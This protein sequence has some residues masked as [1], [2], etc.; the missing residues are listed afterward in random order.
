MIGQIHLEAPL[1]TTVDIDEPVLLAVKGLAA[2]SGKSMGKV[3]SEL[4]ARALEP[5]KPS[6]RR[7]GLPV[8]PYSGQGGPATMDLVNRLRDGDEP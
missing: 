8:A 6:A 1:R 2:Q 4:L 7:N 5:Q 3:I